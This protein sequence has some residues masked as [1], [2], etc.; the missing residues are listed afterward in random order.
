MYV[1]SKN[2]FILFVILNTSTP[3]FAQSF[4][5]NTTGATA[6]NSA[7]FDVSCTTKGMLVPRVTTVQ[8]NGIASPATG[9]LVYDTNLNQFAF[10]NGTSWILLTTGVNSWTINGSNQYSNVAG[11]VGIGTITPAELL[12]VNGK[13]RTNQLQITT[14]AIN[15]YVLQTDAAGNA[16][17]VNPAGLIITETDP[18][19]SSSSP[20]FIPRWN[21]ATLVD[22][23]IFDNGTGNIGI[24]NSL[25]NADLTVGSTMAI[26]GFSGIANFNT[27]GNKPLFVGETAGVKGII[28]GYDGNNI[29]GRSG[30]TFSNNGDLVLN[31]YAGN[32]GI[33]TTSPGEKLDVNGKT[34]TI[35]LQVTAGAANGFMLQSDASGNASWVDP[36]TA[37]TVWSTLGNSGTN[38]AINFI[39]TTDAQPLL[40]KVNNLQAGYISLNTPFATAFGYKALMNNTATGIGNAAFG[41]LAL[42]SNT[43]GYNNLAAGDSTLSNN[44]TGYHNVAAGCA[45]LYANTTGLG[46]T[47]IGYAT[48]QN[49]VSTLGINTAVGD[50]AITSNTSGNRNAALGAS[51]LRYNTSG[52]DNVAVGAF[53]VNGTS[54]SFNVGVGSYTLGNAT[55]SNN[56]AVGYNA[57]NTGSIGSNNTA[58]G[59]ATTNSGNGN[60]N[61]VIGYSADVKGSNNTVIGANAGI[62]TN[63]YSNATVIGYNATAGASNTVILG[64]GAS[65]GIGTGSPTQKLEVVGTTKTTGLQLT[66]GAANGYVL[67]SDAA[68]TG[69]WVDPAVLAITE[70]D[71]QV[72]STTTGRI[73]RW[74]GTA[75]V[76]GTAF[77]NGTNIGIGTATPTQA[78]LVV[79]GSASLTLA[80]GFL[81]SSGGTGTT[82]GTNAYSIYASDR[83]AG[84]EF[85]AY[86]DERIKKIIG[87]SNN[88]ADL[89]ILQQIAI[90]NYRLKDSISKGNRIYRKVIAQ[91]LEKV[92][93]NAVSRIQD[94]VPDIYQQATI[95]NSKILLVNNLKAGETV[96]MIFQDGEQ[97][98]KVIN[99][100]AG[101]FT[102]NSNRNG[103]VFVYGRQVNDFRTVDYE[104]LTTLNISATQEL[105]KQVAEQQAIIRALQEEL[106]KLSNLPDNRVKE[107]AGVSV[108]R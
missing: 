9:L 91:Q 86:S 26:G 69:T 103:N 36:A 81:N 7:I 37:N 19:V 84:L 95:S 57:F 94:V 22:G 98:V 92:Y 63:T 15:N 34:K 8:R 70:T 38:P 96:K 2:I 50:Y 33:G 80:Y 12:H 100:D 87:I 93:P 72:S 52:S 64:S 46:N 43:T 21:G 4:A 45:S 5:I 6:D 16:S 17:W 62:G 24:G 29:Q 58:V 18:Q 105:A 101:S 27:T 89:Q 106:K 78:K 39:G 71:P 11:N 74:N 73:P 61:I 107:N 30:P 3:V 31:N 68:G 44:T 66:G 53:S 13:T 47:A 108:N 42:S 67:Q 20:N 88:A 41:Y 48:L 90:T 99:A 77:D 102:I 49:N 1:V 59:A 55:S 82:S 56:T 51:A 35:S 54:G 10:Y 76:D 14:G 85:N 23:G 75:L 60:N 104:A 97:L 65:V 79:N 28:I 25:A 32:V 83:I 40:I